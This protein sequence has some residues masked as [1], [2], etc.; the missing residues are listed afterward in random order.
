M[1][2]LAV[3]AAAHPGHERRPRSDTVRRDAKASRACAAS[4]RQVPIET[5]HVLHAGMY[6]RTICIPA[7]VLITGALVKVADAADRS[8]GHA[9]VV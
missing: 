5:R 4:C 2:E 6:A 3:A 1:A 7:G 9:T 8:S